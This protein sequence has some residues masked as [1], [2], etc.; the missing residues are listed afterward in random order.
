MVGWIFSTSNQFFNA[1]SRIWP[2]KKSADA[3]KPLHGVSSQPP[4]RDNW[5]EVIVR[6]DLNIITNGQLQ[7][8]YG[9]GFFLNVPGAAHDVIVTAG[10]HLIRP[11]KDAQSQPELTSKIDVQIT[12]EEGNIMTE[13]VT[14]DRY[15]ICT[16]YK[17]QPS[18][19]TDSAD[20]YGVILLDRPIVGGV[21]TPRKAFS[22]NIIL[23][24][25][26]L[27]TSEP[28]T[29]L[30]GHVGGYPGNKQDIP[31]DHLKSSSVTASFGKHGERQLYYHADTGQGM[32]G[33]P[34]W[35]KFQG[36]DIAVG[37]QWAGADTGLL[38]KVISVHQGISPSPLGDPLLIQCGIQTKKKVGVESLCYS[39]SGPTRDPELT[40]F[41]IIPAKCSPTYKN[42]PGG[43]NFYLICHKA[44]GRTTNASPRFLMFDTDPNVTPKQV[45][46]TSKP[47]G[48]CLVKLDQGQQSA[49]PGTFN[50]SQPFKIVTLQNHDLESLSKS[51][52]HPEFK[53]TFWTEDIPPADDEFGLE[54]ARLGLIMRA[55]PH[56]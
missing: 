36:D 9:T 54:R 55:E 18:Q 29:M 28:G 4:D 12:N 25:M 33:G 42:G 40:C 3:A 41:D 53:L 31:T 5:S 27:S 44:P 16:K 45:G 39:W 7:I 14:P 56:E 20:D 24:A 49:G 8:G 48:A 2:W 23:A 13:T 10:H 11:A 34:V 43:N 51:K 52:P 37:I 19:T 32:S 1:A 22:Y 6:L 17:K 30:A 35:V 15:H 46:Y 21:P 50:P 47:E 26:N 38:D